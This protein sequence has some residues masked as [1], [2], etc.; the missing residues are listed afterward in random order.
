MDGRA[1]DFN[2]W[3][4]L[5]LQVLQLAFK[6]VKIASGCMESSRLKSAPWY[7]DSLGL[8]FDPVCV[9]HHRGKLYPINF[10]NLTLKRRQTRARA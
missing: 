4:N 1:N 5:R 7:P 3:T 10:L 6:V 8:K 2:S 9:L